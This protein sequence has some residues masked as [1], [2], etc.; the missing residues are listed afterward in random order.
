[1]VL[2]KRELIRIVITPEGVIIDSTGKMNGRGVYL[3]NQRSCWERGLKGA[4]ASALKTEI[5]AENMLQLKLIMAGLPNENSEEI[6]D[7]D[8]Q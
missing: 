2:P 4:V 1:M 3:H 7:S 5:N 8:G 6:A